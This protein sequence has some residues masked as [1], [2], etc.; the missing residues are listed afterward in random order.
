MRQVRR[1]ELIFNIRLSMRGL[2][3]QLRKDLLSN[4]SDKRRRAEDILAAIITDRALKKY[5]ILSN[6]PEG[7][8]CPVISEGAVGTG[9][10]GFE[11]QSPS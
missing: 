1:D 3:I 9:I 5:E 11:D 10:G 7:P 2:A 6:T 4:E 8:P